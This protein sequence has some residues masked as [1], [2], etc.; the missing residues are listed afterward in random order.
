[1]REGVRADPALED[2]GNLLEVLAALAVDR[3]RVGAVLAWIAEVA[4][5][6]V[7]RGGE[8]DDRAREDP[9]RSP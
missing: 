2:E 9:K 5:K 4:L 3:D 6:S 1:M 7:P 8:G